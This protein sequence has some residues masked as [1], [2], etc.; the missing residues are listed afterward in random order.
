MGL[1]YLELGLIIYG[2]DSV[3]VP[4]KIIVHCRLG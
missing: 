2:L 1:I 4:E 3:S